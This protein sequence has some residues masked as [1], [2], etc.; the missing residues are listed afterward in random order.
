MITSK[1]MTVFSSTTL[2]GRPLGQV[3]RSKMSSNMFS[4]FMSTHM[5]HRGPH[6]QTVPA[7][8]QPSIPYVECD[9]ENGG[10]GRRYSDLV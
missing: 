5:L 1:V 2:S 9:V 10:N 4:E 7:V 3:M 6:L 8:E